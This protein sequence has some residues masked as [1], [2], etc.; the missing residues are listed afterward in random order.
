MKTMSVVDFQLL[1][2]QATQ[3]PKTHQDAVAVYDGVEAMS[4]GE[5]RTVSE[6]VPY[7]FLYQLVCPVATR[8][9][10]KKNNKK[11]NYRA[12]T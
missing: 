12:S 9:V 4:D 7:G 3:R 1:V 8:C 6:L 5:H 10:F 11:N 2:I